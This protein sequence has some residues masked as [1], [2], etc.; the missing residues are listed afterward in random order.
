VS[1]FSAGRRETKTRTKLRKA[2]Q[3]K[4][5][6]LTTSREL[7]LLLK[8]AEA[9]PSPRSKSYIKNFGRETD[10]VRA[11]VSFLA[12]KMTLRDMLEDGLTT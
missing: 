3:N 5:E 6:E 11:D 2:L 1:T 4:E 8:V 12:K 10:R 7:T 9:P